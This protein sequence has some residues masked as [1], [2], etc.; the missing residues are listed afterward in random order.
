MSRDFW[1]DE[2]IEKLRQCVLDGYSA[3]ETRK[4]LG[5]T[6]NVAIGKAFR[7]GMHFGIGTA[8]TREAFAA[9]LAL[10]ARPKPKAPAPRPAAK[11]TPLFAPRIVPQV[12]GAVSLIALEPG[13]CRW[14]IDMS[15]KTTAG[16]DS[17]F[18][19]KPARDECAWCV[20]H[21]A[22]AFTPGPATDEERARARRKFE[23]NL[24]WYAA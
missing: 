8:P 11:P 22:L 17:L 12:A 4:A 21:A 5:C 18:C 13:Q 10:K 1:T 20:E 2:R 24:R 9:R 6:R 23:R 16:A 3:G 19:G 14:P 15:V 7:L